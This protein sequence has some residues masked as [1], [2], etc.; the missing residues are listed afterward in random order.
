M[1]QRAHD[2]AEFGIEGIDVGQEDVLKQFRVIQQSALHYK[3]LLC[4]F[5]GLTCVDGY[6]H[7]YPQQSLPTPPIDILESVIFQ[8]E[9]RAVVARLSDWSITHLLLELPRK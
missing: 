8:L 7:H 3:L 6:V 5:L 1:Q 9:N 4:L 2:F